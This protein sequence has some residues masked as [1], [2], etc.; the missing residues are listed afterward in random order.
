MQPPADLPD[1]EG[2]PIA[3]M[4][5]G[6]VSRSLV[7]KFILVFAAL[8]ITAVMIAFHDKD[9]IAER[10]AAEEE[11][12]RQQQASQAQGNPSDLGKIF[13]AQAEAG[14]AA[15]ETAPRPSDAALAA[16]AGAPGS[17]GSALDMSNALLPG[18]RNL[19][20]YR[21]RRDAVAVVNLPIYLDDREPRRPDGGAAGSA[22]QIQLAS[23]VSPAGATSP[24]GV[25]PPQS[26][27]LD[28]LYRAMAAG[29]QGGRLPGGQANEDWLR[30]TQGAEQGPVFAQPALIPG[31]TL[32][33][34]SIIPA[35]TVRGLN[36]DLPGQVTVQVT[37]D[38]YDTATG[39]NLLIPKGT[40]LVGPYNADVVE[41]QERLL[42]AF[43]Q[44]IY[45][46]GATV[47]LPGMPASDLAGNSGVPAEVDS[48]FWRIFGSS[49][50]VAG[51]T[52]LLTPS[53][54]SDNTVIINAGTGLTGAAGQ[55]LVDTAKRILD[56]NQQIRP[57]LTFGY[58]E[59]LNVEV[60]RDLVL[61]PEITGVVPRTE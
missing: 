6:L 17:G 57:T 3:S 27:Q 11:K 43:Q 47:N 33:R 25:Q 60:T 58:G 56:R 22:R 20:N 2:D 32:R 44:L 46:N 55:V 1:P 45:L 35:V 26:A 24:E 19:E 5:R 30:S 52:R 31:Y 34:G 23:P 18:E 51:L 12:R 13:L 42:A 14:K 29:A 59:K 49:F 37:Q 10:R 53:Y 36:S 21:Q 39:Q 16:L 4:R 7:W 15:R 50:L 40:R 54:Q 61:P 28:A 41:N 38:V 48:H 8:A 9:P